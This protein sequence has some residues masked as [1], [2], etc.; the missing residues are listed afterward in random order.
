MS[1]VKLKVLLPKV[2]LQLQRTFRGFVIP[3]SFS[4]KWL[5]IYFLGTRSYKCQGQW[6]L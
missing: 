3:G 6:R 5:M 1:E 4:E 2:D